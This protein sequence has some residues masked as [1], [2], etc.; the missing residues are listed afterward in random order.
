[1]R[2]VVIAAPLSAGVL[3]APSRAAADSR[4]GESHWHFTITLSS[5]TIT[6]GESVTVSVSSPHT[7]KVF[8]GM[9]TDRHHS[10]VMSISKT[11]ATPTAS[12]AGAV[13]F[14]SNTQ[15]SWTD[16]LDNR[17]ANNL[18]DGRFNSPSSTVT[19][20]TVDDNAQTG[21]RTVTVSGSVDYRAGT[22]WYNHGDVTPTITSTTLTILDND[23]PQ[24]GLALG[25]STIAESGADN[26]T[27][28]RATLAAAATEAV[29]V[30]VGPAT[31]EAF[32]WSGTTLTIPSGQT[33]SSSTVT[34]TA[35]DDDIAGGNK[36]VT[37][38]ASTTSNNYRGST[39]TLTITDD[40]TPGV[41]VDTDPGTPAVVNTAALGVS[42]DGTMTTDAYTVVLD[43]DPGGPVTV[44]VGDDTTTTPGVNDLD[45]VRVQ[46]GRWSSR[47][48]TGTRRRR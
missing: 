19:I 31:S 5:T 21:H 38:T 35:T 42:E 4:G 45:K 9:N 33:Q 13:N 23:V 40:E 12:G 29:T 17:N 24:I 11:G 41:T 48:G 30:T 2:A 27:T 47:R 18:G 44:T 37:L 39:A 36:S 6:E 20:S 7:A 46:P 32:M 43:T 14:G 10:A 28:V 8:T 3:C 26:A 16:Y 1:M 34:L 25:S 22:Y 15:V